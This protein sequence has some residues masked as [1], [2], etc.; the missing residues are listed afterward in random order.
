MDD[1]LQRK[2]EVVASIEQGLV[3][4][5]KGM[6]PEQIVDILKNTKRTKQAQG[7]PIGLNYLMGF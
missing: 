1:N 5:E 7:G 3:M 6:S 4:Q 2:A